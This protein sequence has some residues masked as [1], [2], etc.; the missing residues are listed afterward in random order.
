MDRWMAGARS[1]GI[2]GSEQ[3]RLQYEPALQATLA[4]E[5]KKNERRKDSKHALPG[6]HQHGN[7]EQQQNPSKQILGDSP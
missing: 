3:G 6:Q 2:Q 5:I 1:Q 7:S 4:G